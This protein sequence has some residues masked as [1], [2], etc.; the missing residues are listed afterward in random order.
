MFMRSILLAS[1]LVLSTAQAFSIPPNDG[2][3]T[4]EAGM[5]DKDQEQIMET[6]LSAYEDETSNEIAV[7]IIETLEGEP[8]ADTAFEVGRAWGVG[9]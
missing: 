1:F 6:M 5:L 7:L 9:Q 4:D 8:I 3:V 2:F